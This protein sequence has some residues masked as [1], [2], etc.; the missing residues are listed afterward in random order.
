MAKSDFIFDK[1]TCSID[2]CELGIH[3]KGYCLKHYTRI[4]KWNDPYKLK[5]KPN[6]TGKILYTCLGCNREFFE[7]DFRMKRCRT[8]MC[9]ECRAEF[10]GQRAVRFKAG[11]PIRCQKHGVHLNWYF[12]IRKNGCEVVSCRFCRLENVKISK[13]NFDHLVPYLVHD[14]K[15]RRPDN[16]ELDSVFIFELLAKQNYC[17]ALTGICFNENVWP[18]ID[19]ID[20]SVGYLK[21]NVQ[22]VT[23]TVNRA[24]WNLTQDQFVGLCGQVTSNFYNN[25]KLIWCI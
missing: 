21:S 22:L 12:S 7:Y 18:S 19:R 13:S 3:Q 1:G 4:R 24:K 11:L 23:G 9:K 2:D 10:K 5:R 8:V 16:F 14:A 17:C 20:S 25:Q 15:K 6:G